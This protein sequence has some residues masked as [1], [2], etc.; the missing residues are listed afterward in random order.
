MRLNS[1]CSRWEERKK[2]D[3]FFRSYYFLGQAI[4]SPQRILSLPQSPCEI[5]DRITN[6]QQQQENT[7]IR[8]FLRPF[9]A[10]AYRINDRRIEINWPDRRRRCWNLHRS[11]WPVEGKGPIHR[12]PIRYWTR[13][14]LNKCPVTR[15]SSHCHRHCHSHLQL[16][17]TPWQ[18]ENVHCLLPPSV[19][20]RFLSSTISIDVRFDSQSQRHSVKGRKG[21]N[22][23]N[24]WAPICNCEQKLMRNGAAWRNDDEERPWVCE[25][26]QIWQ[27]H[28]QSHWIDHCSR[29]CLIACLPVSGRLYSTECALRCECNQT[30]A[31][32]ICRRRYCG[33]RAGE[34]GAAQQIT[35]SD[36]VSEKSVRETD[37]G[38]VSWRV[39]H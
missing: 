6:K 12:Q 28:S 13:C 31:D 22:K 16:P 25:N 35:Y 29:F 23:C 33:G 10:A 4:S 2:E 32:C 3:G 15:T 26:G 27:A 37:C 36:W 14:V 17:S 1:I 19:C 11:N 5:L 20:C 7:K 8:S 18:W 30:L 21:N 39:C 38:G 24:K 9:L 34:R